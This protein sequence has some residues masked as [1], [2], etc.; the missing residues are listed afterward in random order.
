MDRGVEQLVDGSDIFGHT[1]LYAR[2]LPASA[3]VKTHPTQTEAA[4][5]TVY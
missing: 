1:N 4:H 3:A 2:F 5:I